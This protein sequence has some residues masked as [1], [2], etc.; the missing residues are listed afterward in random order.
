MEFNEVNLEKLMQADINMRD[1]IEKL[2]SQVK[3]IKQKR[4]LVQHALIEACAALNVS[5][6]KTKVGTLT[7]SLKTR[8]WTSDWPA[9]HKFMKEHDA[10][11]LMEKRIAQGNFKEFLEKNPDLIPPGL[12]ADQ[13]YTVV[14]RRN[15]DNKE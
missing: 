15:K 12:Q 5:G 7:R 3:D 10:L 1:E 13:E 8:Y 11:D 2:E 4:E 9:M 14:I 6:L